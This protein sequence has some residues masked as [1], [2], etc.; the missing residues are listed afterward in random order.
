MRREPAR[1]PRGR[2]FARVCCG[3]QA[4]GVIVRLVQAPRR[5]SRKRWPE[6]PPLPVRPKPEPVEIK[7]DG[8]G[9]VEGQELAQHKPADDRNPKRAAHLAALESS[10]PRA[11]RQRSRQRLSSKLDAAARDRREKSPRAVKAHLCARHPA[12]NRS[13]RSHFS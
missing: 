2:A 6:A 11:A 5:A 8:G 3:V 10:A 13:S 9:G 7:I 1:A 4:A 12:R